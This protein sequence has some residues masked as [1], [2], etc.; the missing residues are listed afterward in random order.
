MK[1][2][3]VLLAAIAMTTLVVQANEAQPVEIKVSSMDTPVSAAAAEVTAETEDDKNKTK[4]KSIP[5]ENR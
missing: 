2:M 4:E 5:E 1:R 3:M